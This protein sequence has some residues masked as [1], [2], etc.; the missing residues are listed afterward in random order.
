MKEERGFFSVLRR[1]SPMTFAR[2]MEL[3]LYHPE[4]G[5]YARAP[6]IGKR[7]DFFTSPAVHPVFGAAL[8]KQVLEI[9]EGMGSPEDFVL[10]EAGAGEGYLALDILDFLWKKG[11]TFPYFI[12][13]PFPANRSRQEEV[14]APYLDQVQWFSTW[15]EVPLFKGVFLSNELFDSFPVHLVEKT[16]DDLREVYV[17]CEERLVEVL[18]GLSAPEILERVLPYAS[19]WPEGY[20][21][22]VS[23]AYA[24][25]FKELSKRL[26]SGAVITIDYGYP[27]PD[28]YHPDRER[29]TL[30][31]FYQHQALENPYLY[32]G[33]M[34]LTAHV[35]FTLLKE[36]G[37]RFGL[38]NL[39]F[40]TQAAF[41][42]GLR[43]E[44]LLEELGRTTPRD[45]EALKT[46]LLPQGLG[47]SHWVLLQARGL[48]LDIRLAGFTLSNRLGLL[49]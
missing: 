15:Q 18:G 37:E 29:G 19:C 13:E 43:I 16:A 10:V 22:E 6:K 48:P 3:C 4:F 41:L 36:L 47:M 24:P 40:T 49:F 23:L 33:R 7:G 35:D 21:T 46:L 38:V 26:V 32:P 31:A 25:F 17:L 28:Y 12:L 39:G 42:V 34:D 14:L 9:W 30:L 11:H 45:L 44:L 8:A 1:E 5:Y 27:R 2:Y 20:R